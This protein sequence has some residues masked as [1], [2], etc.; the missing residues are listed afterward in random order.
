MSNT[1]PSEKKT[2]S[3]VGWTAKGRGIFDA[4]RK[5]CARRRH[6]DRHH[7]TQRGRRAPG[8]A[9]ARSRSSRPQCAC[10]RAIDRPA[11][12]R[13]Q[14]RRLCWRRRRPHQGAGAGS[15]AAFGLALARRR[16]RRARGGGIGALS[17][18][19]RPTRSRSP[20]RK[21]RCHRTLAQ[22]L[23]LA[24]HELAT[25]AAKHGALSSMPGKVSL[26]VA[27]AAGPSGPALGRNRR[28]A[29]LRRRRR[30]ASA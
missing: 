26:N 20:A 6:R 4:R 11:D 25:N 21:S 14:R 16:S 24:L 27:I 15:R 30:A 7:Q 23:A 19:P 29:R 2:A 3:F 22:G 9:G 17:G 1:A 5:M 12:A 13:E 8:S 10:R 28:P 18:W